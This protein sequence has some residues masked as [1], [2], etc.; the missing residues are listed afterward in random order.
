MEVKVKFKN[1]KIYEGVDSLE[2]EEYYNGSNRRTLTVKLDKSYSVD[3]LNKLVSDTSNI[4]S[5][6]VTADTWENIYDGYTM[7]LR[8]GV[9]QNLVTEE[10]PETPS[11]YEEVVVLKLGRP[12]YIERQLAKLGIQ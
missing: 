7:K 9:E 2:Q 12:T 11:V 10:T 3:E 1:G 4:E 5:I 6:K 8:L